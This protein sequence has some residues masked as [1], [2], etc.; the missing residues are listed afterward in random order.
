MYMY[1]YGHTCNHEL[2]RPE[3][4]PAYKPIIMLHGDTAVW[5]ITPFTMAKEDLEFSLR[6]VEEDLGRK[7]EMVEHPWNSIQD[8]TE[9]WN[10]VGN[11]DWSEIDLE[12]RANKNFKYW[13]WYQNIFKNHYSIQDWNQLLGL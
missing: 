7:I 2:I 3:T 13:G 8:I 4:H 11:M 1:V 9:L 12:A 5:A 6:L 10:I